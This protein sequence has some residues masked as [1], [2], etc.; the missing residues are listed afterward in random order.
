M[1]AQTG[2]VGVGTDDANAGGRAVG[3]SPR[4]ERAA[5]IKREPAA[6]GGDRVWVSAT[7]TKPPSRT[8]VLRCRRRAREGEESRKASRTAHN[9]SSV[10]NERASV[11]MRR[12]KIVATLGPASEEPA[13]LEQLIQ[14]GTD[15]CRLNLSHGP[16]SDHL[17]RLATVRKI[18]HRVG[19]RV[20]V[21]ADLPGPKITPASSPTTASS[22]LRA[23]PCGCAP[24]MAAAPST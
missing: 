6:G 21:M 15:V 20:A 16:L 1:D 17:R 13:A 12:T 24:A 4:D 23:A 9:H 3:G 11:P 5:L 18:D 22:W 2:G 7:S 8:I 10:E 14:A 19:Q